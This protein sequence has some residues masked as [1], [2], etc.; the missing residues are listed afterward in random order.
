MVEL[1]TRQKVLLVIG[2]V[3]L[4]SILLIVL[5]RPNKDTSL[6]AQ[7]QIFAAEKKQHDLYHWYRERRFWSMLV[8]ALNNHTRNATDNWYPYLVQKP[9]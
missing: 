4:G 7:Q 8:A 1:T 2:V 6:I 5:M 9:M 3:I